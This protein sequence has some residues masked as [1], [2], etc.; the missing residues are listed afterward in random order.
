MKLFFK[1]ETNTTWKERQILRTKNSFYLLYINESVKM[2]AVKNKIKR[3]LTPT[4]MVKEKFFSVLM[5]ILFPS[6]A[7]IPSPCPEEL[8]FSVLTTILFISV[9]TIILKPRDRSTLSQIINLSPDLSQDA[10]YTLK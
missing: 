5:I 4:A 9:S 3:M 6:P 10:F 8:S 2:R 7:P 1:L